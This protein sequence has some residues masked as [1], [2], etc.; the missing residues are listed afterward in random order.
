MYAGSRTNSVH[1]EPFDKVAVRPELVEGDGHFPQDRPVE[2]SNL[3]RHGWSLLLDLPFDKPFDLAQASRA[4]ERRLQ[5]IE[6]PPT[7]LHT[8]SNGALTVC[9]EAASD[10][11]PLSSEARVMPVAGLIAMVFQ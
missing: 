4:T 7:R 8:I 10:S 11:C 1:A 6:F 9:R 3:S 2:V 5:G